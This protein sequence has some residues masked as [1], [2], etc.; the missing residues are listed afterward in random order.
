VVADEYEI[1]VDPA[2]PSGEYLIEVGLYDA[3]QPGYPRLAVS[4]EQG[5]IIGDRVLLKEVRIKP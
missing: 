2:A 5:Q 1:P 4:D 3:A